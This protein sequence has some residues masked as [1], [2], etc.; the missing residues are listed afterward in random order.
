MVH[1]ATSFMDMQ[2]PKPYGMETTPLIRLLPGY[3]VTL[4]IAMTTNAFA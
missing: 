3:Q 2:M 4:I 1:Y